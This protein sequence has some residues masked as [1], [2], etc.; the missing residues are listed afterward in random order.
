M[1]RTLEKLTQDEEGNIIRADGEVMDTQF[2]WPVGKLITRVVEN[3]SRDILEVVNEMVER[4]SP[5]IPKDA[6]A[7]LASDFNCDTQGTRDGKMTSV[8]AIQF[9]DVGEH[10]IRTVMRLEKKGTRVY[11]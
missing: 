10:Y 9:Y 11:P 6:T 8:Y 5:S 4:N 1:K 2:S 7:Y 3:P